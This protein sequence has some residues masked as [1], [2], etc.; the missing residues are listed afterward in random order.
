[1]IKS[2]S[3]SNKLIFLMDIYIIMR[4]RFSSI[5]HYI[6]LLEK[7]YNVNVQ[8]KKHLKKKNHEDLLLLI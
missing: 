5:Y 3:L 2:Q 8:T 7:N 1:M 4:F 6:L